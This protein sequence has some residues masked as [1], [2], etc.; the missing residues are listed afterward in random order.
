MK[1]TLVLVYVVLIGFQ[2]FA[3]DLSI[4]GS[5]G[6]ILF[7]PARTSALSSTNGTFTEHLYYGTGSIKLEQPVADLAALHILLDRDP[8]L[9]NSLFTML[10]YDAGFAKISVGPFFGLFNSA[11]TLVT[12]G[13]S[14]TLTMTLPGV[15]YG[16]FRSDTTIG[17][18]ITVPGDYVQQRSELAFGFWVP[19]VLAS[20]RLNTKQFTEKKT[21]DLTIVDSQSRY[22]FIAL[23]FKKNVPYSVTITMGYQT[24]K[25]SYI[26]T[27]TDSD[28]LAALMLGLDLNSS[29]SQ[30][31]KVT[32]GGEVP[33]YA[34]GV[35]NLQSPAS[36]TLLYEGRIGIT[37]NLDSNPFEKILKGIENTKPENPQM[38]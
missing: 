12:S 19:N 10:S 2:L 7:D 38:E 26:S 27:S 32:A 24:L 36:T 30:R 28:E 22:D 17:A 13:L 35:G 21:A 11:A 29:I 37:I 3:L 14:T 31:I 1:R 23:V 9:R 15:L 33:L 5:F 20:F 6:N 25:R 34:W 4:Q 8:I 18:G 16:S